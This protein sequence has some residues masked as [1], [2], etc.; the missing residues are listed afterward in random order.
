MPSKAI[1]TE[2]QDRPGDRPGITSSVPEVAPSQL[3]EDELGLPRTLGMAGAVLV[4]ASTVALAAYQ[5]GR[6][7]FGISINAGWAMVL[8]I[9]GLCGLLYHAAFDRDV[10]FRRLYVMFALALLA[11][12]PFLCLVPYPK[13]MGDLLRFGAPCMLLAL[14]FFVAGLRNETDEP[15]RRLMETIFGAAGAAMAL[16]GLIGGMLRHEFLMPLG[17][18]FAVF[19]LIYLGAVG[20]HSVCAC[21]LAVCAARRLGNDPCSPRRSSRRTDLPR[22]SSQRVCPSSSVRA[23]LAITH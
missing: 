6:P 7:L 22:S 10:M 3:R 9:V 4:I 13:A 20:A 11:L 5:S 14:L 21:R 17:L 18:V 19:G 1:T 23:R 15:F 2:Q 8:M 12:G 16:G